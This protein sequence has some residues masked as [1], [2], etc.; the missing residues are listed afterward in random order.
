M[1][2][3]KRTIIIAVGLVLF[4]GFLLLATFLWVGKRLAA[5]AAAPTIDLFATLSA[6]TPV[7]AF[8]PAPITPTATSAF[9]FSEPPVQAETPATDATGVPTASSG[10]G[11][12]GHIVFTCQL[13]KYQAADQICIMNA[14]G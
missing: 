1:T 6:S 9:D 8:S 4:C 12:A 2:N 14:D 7:S 11:P 13:F 10:D 3:K 5:P